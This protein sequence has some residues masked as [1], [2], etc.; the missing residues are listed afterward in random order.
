MN[1]HSPI[2]AIETSGDLCSVC[3]YTDDST[4]SEESVLGKHIHSEKIYTIIENVCRSASIEL[5][6]LKSIA[7]SIGPGS[8][9][10]LRIGLAAAKAIAMGKK[11]P[12]I[13]VPSYNA[14]A[15]ELAKFVEVNKEFALGNM[16][17]REELYYAR[18]KVSNEGTECLQ[19]P[20]LIFLKD[21]KNHLS[22]N[23]MLFGKLNSISESKFKPLT[24]IDIARWAYVFGNESLTY[25]YDFLEPNYLKNFVAKVKK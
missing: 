22:G 2:L 13:P 19:G 4:Y 18:Y 9:T 8:F 20:E 1:D 21:I 14:H 12:I 15:Q 3:L 7:V 5:D 10:G 6:E 11:L 17:N 23:E 16:V 25:D 24:S